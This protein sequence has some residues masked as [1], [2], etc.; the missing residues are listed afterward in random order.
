MLRLIGK[1]DG[2]NKNA[3]IAQEL[4]KRSVFKQHDARPSR[5]SLR[6]VREKKLG[7]PKLAALIQKHHRRC[8]AWASHAVRL[9]I[10][11]GILVDINNSLGNHRPIEIVFGISLTGRVGRKF[12]KRTETRGQALGEVIR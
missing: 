12:V 7:S 5:A 6:E 2:L 9:T 4:D 10:S 11:E 3:P 1:R 8:M